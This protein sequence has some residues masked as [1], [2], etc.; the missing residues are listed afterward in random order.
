MQNIGPFK[1]T[2]V[3]K[4]VFCQLAIQGNVKQM[5]SLCN[6]NPERLFS[7]DR[8]GAT[9]LHHAAAANRVTVLELALSSPGGSECKLLRLYFS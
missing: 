3:N 9:I 4:R 6:V 7:L 5:A 8:K 2:N 1:D